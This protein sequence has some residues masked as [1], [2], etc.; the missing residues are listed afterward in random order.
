MSYIGNNP[1]NQNFVA[2]ADQFN[3]TGSQ[4]VFTLSRNVN[5]VFDMF[6]TVSNVP[7][8]PFT[9]YTVAGNSLTFT[10]APPSGTG[11]IDVVYRATNVQTFVPSPGVSQQ[12]SIGTAAS[13]AITFIGDT[14]TGI[15]SP[16]ADT[17]AFVEGGVEA[18]RINS[19]ANV[20]IGTSS[21]ATKLDVNGTITAT[22][23]TGALTSATGLPLTTGVTGTLPVANGGTGAA[24]LTA[25][26][27]I[28]GN[29]TSAVSFVAPSTSGNVLTSNGTTWTSAAAAGI[30]VGQTWTNVTASRA[31]GTTYTNSTGKPIMVVVTPVASGSL[32]GT[33][34]IS[35]SAVGVVQFTP[36]GGGGG[37]PFFYII[38]NG[39][40]YSVTNNANFNINFWWELR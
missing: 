2:G 34:N 8:D 20:G 4:T 39:V 15:Y 5:T 14:N 1:V 19:S 35:G 25:N 31:T 27:V 21:P 33:F 13:P 23:F 17:I 28:L 29:G 6:V 36:S 12:F 3:G 22:T 37:S 30:G 32:I 26:N 16:G 10:S 11:N 38:P 24:S 7:Q 9:A 40:T 18:M